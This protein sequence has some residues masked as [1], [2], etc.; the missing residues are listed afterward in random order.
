MTRANFT[1]DII[2][3]DGFHVDARMY[4][5]TLDDVTIAAAVADIGAD[6]KRL[7]IAPGAW[8]ISPA[9]GDLEIPANIELYIPMGAVMTVASGDTLTIK[10]AFTAGL[11][12]VFSTTAG[13]AAVLF[14]GPMEGVYPEWFA[15]ADYGLQIN[16]AIASIKAVGGKIKF[17]QSATITTSINATN[18]TKGLTFEGVAS[19]HDGTATNLILTFNLSTVC[20]DCCGSNGIYFNN[21]TIGT[22][23]NTPTIGFLLARTSASSSGGHVFN[24]VRTNYT[25][26]FSK[27]EIY[28]N[29]SETNQYYSCYF[30]NNVADTP[31][32][33]LT[34][35]NIDSATSSYVTIYD[36]GTTPPAVSNSVYDFFGCEIL[37]LGGGNADCFYFDAAVDFHM[38]G[39]FLYNST[40][41]S[42][43]Y[44][45]LLYASSDGTCISGI[46]GERSGSGPTYG[47]EF[48]N[49]SG[50]MRSPTGWNINSCTFTVDT[51]LI[52]ADATAF[53]TLDN[54][55]YHGID[56]PSAKGIAAYAIQ[57]ST[58]NTGLSPLTIATGGRLYRSIWYGFILPTTPT[59][60]FADGILTGLLNSIVIDFVTGSVSESKISGASATLADSAT[61][62]VLGL[63]RC[64]TGSTRT[65]E[66]FLNGF[67]G[68]VLILISNHSIT[69]TDNATIVLNGS[70]NFVMANTDTLTLINSGGVWYETA[71]SD[72]T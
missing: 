67:D 51:R 49:T 4:G 61:P 40:G 8:D 24:K 12:E 63:K 17:T 52:K 23:T 69:I 62:S 46:R 10:G 53:V 2:I 20:F 50:V 11:Y 58:I 71:R 29:G 60:N 15:G 7:L 31:T 21:F 55:T 38:F 45:D 19:P 18:I 36:P 3:S 48:A 26:E 70:A 68:Q 28:S 39:G 6:E 56:D 22:V 27:A 47:F 59:S 42:Y 37:N 25:A 41:R 16:S 13:E 54:F 65:I 5:A 1:P 30:I 32:I 14:E 44:I 35:H 72:N 9:S 66:N 57:Y 43:F 33:C 34:S 64:F